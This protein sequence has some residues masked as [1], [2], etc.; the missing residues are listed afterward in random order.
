M[1]Q[2]GFGMPK[3]K[4]VG[5][6]RCPING[7]WYKEYPALGTGDKS[8]VSLVRRYNVRGGK[9]CMWWQHTTDSNI[10]WRK[11]KNDVRHDIS[12]KNGKIYTEEMKLSDAKTL[13]FATADEK[14]YEKAAK[15]VINLGFE[16]WSLDYPINPESAS[17]EVRNK[18]DAK[19]KAE[20]KK[21]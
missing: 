16:P 19:L 7:L 6:V 8:S 20:S 5:H 12:V 13:L 1:A 15:Q 4:R 2:A 21:K 9:P 17:L 3:T 14:S 10:A 11:V 18:V